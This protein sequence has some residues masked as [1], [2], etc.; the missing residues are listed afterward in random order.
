MQRD[1][2]WDVMLVPT[3]PSQGYICGDFTEDEE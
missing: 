1:G 2:R 3:E